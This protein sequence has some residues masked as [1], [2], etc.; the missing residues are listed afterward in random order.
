MK[1]YELIQ[2]LPKNHLINVISN[3]DGNP[4]WSSYFS[5]ERGNADAM[6]KFW[7]T[8]GDS[9]VVYCEPDEDAYNV[10]IEA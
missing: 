3:L 8:Y 2:A 4:I 6:D 5:I 10:Y 7:D 9:D 1:I